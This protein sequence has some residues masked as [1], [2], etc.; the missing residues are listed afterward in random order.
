MFNPYS[1]FGPVVEK[2]SQKPFVDRSPIDIITNG[3]AADVPWLT[4]VTSEEGLYPAAEF[5]A[6]EEYM[7]Q[8]DVDWD[9]IA[10]HLLDFN[11]TIPRNKHVEVAQKIRKHYLG[12]KKINRANAQTLIHLM[13]DRLFV[14][15]GEKSAELMAKANRNPVWFYFYSYRAEY[16]LSDDYIPTK[17]NF[18]MFFVFFYA[19]FYLN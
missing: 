13:G 7:E 1:P 2:K 14:V 4:S 12:S 10:P 15:D 11:F 3:E 17:D 5:V 16:S 18:G 8:L 19:K 9:R 6:N